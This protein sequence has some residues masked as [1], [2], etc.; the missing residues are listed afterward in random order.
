MEQRIRI[1]RGDCEIELS[2]DRDFVESQ[3]A[4][5]LPQLLGTEAPAAPTADAMR[6]VPADFAPKRNLDLA[7]LVALKQARAPQDLMLV[8]A[9]YLEKYLRQESYSATELAD[10]LGPLPGWECQSIDEPLELA[11]TQGFLEKLRNGRYT[12]TFKGQN[13]VRDGLVS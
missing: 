9:Y 6:R 1:K 3:L 11:L 10:S 13:Y 7:G 2:G 12:L 8:G 4:K 5:L